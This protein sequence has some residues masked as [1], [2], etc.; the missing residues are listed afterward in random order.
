M[1]RRLVRKRNANK[2]ANIYDVAREAGVSVF[3]VSAVAN[4]SGQV[5][6]SLQRRV[7]AAIEK[8]NY[9]PNLLARSLAKRQTHTIGIIVPDIANP[10][11]PQ[12]VRGAEDTAQKGGYSILLCNSDN[13]PEKEEG[14]LEL[15][16]SKRVDG[17]LLTKAPGRFT[18]VLRRMLS[19]VKVPIVL[20]MRT[21]PDVKADAVLTDDLRGAF[22]AVSH[23][24]RVGYCKVAL[25]GG[26]MNVS[27]GRA[28]WQGYRKGLKACGLPYD[29]ALVFEGDY[30]VDSGYRAG[31]ALLPRRP[32]A[33]YIANYLMTVGFM[34]AAE[35]MGMQ[36]PED[37]GLVSFDDYPWLGCF[38]PRLTTVDLPK[39]ELGAEAARLL[40]ERLKCKQG[41]PVI[42][43]LTPQLVVRESCGFT[44]RR[45]NP[46][47]EHDVV[48][49]LTRGGQETASRLPAGERI[50]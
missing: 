36:C 47:R 13:Q 15:L 2:A 37:F 48:D 31:L 25:V 33:V 19:D 11:F 28:R 35:E 14:Y 4:K 49:T 38:R 24:A 22:E 43:K 34:K 7:E 1:N 27:N 46:V 12:V 50:L 10:F 40:L 26:P 20:V 21:C 17:I 3:T 32:D 30:R 16:L 29:P 6:S 45:R 41:P 9:R 42:Q 5:S 39:Y 23:L 18:P 44:F 8:L